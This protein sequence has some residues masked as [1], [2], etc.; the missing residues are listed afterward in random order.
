MLDLKY[1]FQQTL[2]SENA[3]LYF[4]YFSK[5]K[6]NSIFHAISFFDDIKKNSAWIKN[7]ADRETLQANASQLVSGLK[8]LEIKLSDILEQH[9]YPLVDVSTSFSELEPKV[10]TNNTI[11]FCPS[12]GKKE[13]YVGGG[14][15]GSVIIC[16]RGNKCGEKTQFVS[17]V[18]K[19]DNI[20]FY[21]AVKKLADEVGVDIKAIQRNS[22]IHMEDRDGRE[23]LDIYKQAIVDANKKKI[24]HAAVKTEYKK[25]DIEKSFAK[26][27]IEKLYSKYGV[28]NDTQKMQTIM[29]Y[30]K[31]FSMK[32]DIDR[33]SLINFYKTRGVYGE[34]NTAEFGFLQASRI[35]KLVEGLKEKFGVDDLVRFEIL[36]SGSHRWKFGAIGEDEKFFYCDASVL[37]MTSPYG[38]VPTNLEFRYIPDDGKKLKTKTGSLENK[39]FVEPNYFGK[40]HNVDI[41]KDESQ[42]EIWLHEGHI[43]AK[44][45]SLYGYHA[46]S[47]IGVHKHYDELLG[48]YKGKTVILALDQDKAGWRNLE[49]LA[50]KLKEAGVEHVF[51]ATWDDKNGKDIN[52]L[53]VNGKINSIQYSYVSINAEINRYG[54]EEKHIALS[55]QRKPINQNK[56]A[57]ALEEMRQEKASEPLLISSVNSHISSFV[58]VSSPTKRELLIAVET[59]EKKRNEAEN[60][61]IHRIDTSKSLMRLI[62]ESTAKT[63]NP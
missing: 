54:V 22:E 20:N 39:E 10:S 34:A 57:R 38:D 30:I 62:E 43:D 24:L 29:G 5:I 32:D 56:I 36:S 60:Q 8:S 12:C 42:K 46:I 55:L 58:E 2:N 61:K 49:I 44:T 25:L 33:I 6:L 17:Y 26:V 3:A 45:M 16:N 35:P 53:H 11:L 51:C 23:K 28:M 37:F 21:D 50:I 1:Y 13:A 18:E 9:I 59:L 40:A 14:G 41:L 27:D 63:I 52:E 31:N 15:K 48:Y 19:R 7:E 4:K 47:L